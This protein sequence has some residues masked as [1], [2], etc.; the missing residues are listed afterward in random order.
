MRDCSKSAEED[1]VRSSDFWSA[2]SVW[3][4]LSSW[5]VTIWFE[6]YGSVLAVMFSGVFL[7]T[8]MFV[9]RSLINFAENSR[10]LAT[11]VA[12]FPVS[13]WMF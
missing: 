4:C 1:C 3:T 7:S 2:F 13:F 11:A 5:R 8:V 12:S 10:S 6:T 9:P